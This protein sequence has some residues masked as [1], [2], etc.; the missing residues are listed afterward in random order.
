MPLTDSSPRFV[1]PGWTLALPFLAFTF[2]LFCPREPLYM[3]L[4]STSVYAL[5]P[6]LF[7]SCRMRVQHYLCPVNIALA[8]MFLRLAAVPMLIMTAGPE[9]RVLRV[10]PSMQSME[11]ALAI[12]TVA[13]VAFCLSLALA[14]R[15]L[16]GSRSGGTAQALAHT[17]GLMMTW[18]FAGFGL[19]GFSSAFGNLSNIVLYFTQPEEINAMQ[20][21]LEGTWTGFVGTIFRPFM[22]YAFIAWWSRVADESVLRRVATGS[23]RVALMRSVCVG[24]VSAIGITLANLTFSLNR[25]A[26]V[27]PLVCMAAVYSARIRRIPFSATLAAIAVFLP[28]LIAVE[29][30]RGSIQPGA[31]KT[32][33]TLASAIGS[34]SEN[35]Q[36]Y[37][38][39]PQYT[40]LFYDHLGWGEHLYGGSMIVASIMSPV[41]QLGKSFRETNA[42]AIYNFAMYGVRGIE[43]QICPFASELFANFHMPGVIAGFLLLGLF[44]TQAEQWFDAAKT[45]FAA[46]S[47]Q[48]IALWGALLVV[49][50]I[51]IY[52]QIIIYFFCPV[53]FYLMVFQAR[54]WLRSFHPRPTPRPALSGQSHSGVTL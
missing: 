54:A 1:H 26:F 45:T 33:A 31:K 20:L 35:I 19:L 48:Y 53:Y 16:L 49:W 51:S 5:M 36:A 7:P 44:L 10:L 23:R 21:S 30:Y 32:E 11:G 46:F 9:S 40:G 43:D 4:V 8:L 14:P 15:R 13:Y 2:V 24:I 39:G 18:V 42:G 6:F 34:L 47:I 52:S 38:P 22:A 29:T 12:D 3:S 27:F 37:S 28:I 50:S 17:P 25:A 41:P